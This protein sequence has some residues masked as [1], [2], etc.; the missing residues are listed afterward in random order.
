MTVTH[1]PE[2]WEVLGRMYGAIANLA[3]E[4]EAKGYKVIASLSVG[5]HPA[6]SVIVP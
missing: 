1:T 4:L 3:N 6:R 2:N 5:I